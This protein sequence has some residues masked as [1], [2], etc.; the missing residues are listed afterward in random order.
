MKLIKSYDEIYK[1]IYFNRMNL[2]FK[3]SL[4]SKVSPDILDLI[5]DIKSQFDT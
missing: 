3:T 1:Y 5:S 2:A 4:N